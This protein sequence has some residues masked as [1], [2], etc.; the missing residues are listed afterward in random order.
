MGGLTSTDSRCKMRTWDLRF[1]D[2]PESVVLWNPAGQRVCSS[3]PLGRVVALLFFASLVC[4]DYLI[5]NRRA[6]V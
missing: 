3:S 4:S 1:Y 2:S 5:F 6:A